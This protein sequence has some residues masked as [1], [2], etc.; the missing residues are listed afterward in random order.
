LE[1]VGRWLRSRAC[2]RT[3]EVDHAACI[4]EP[5]AVAVQL[6]AFLELPLNV[7]AMAAAVD[8]SLHRQRHGA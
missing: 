6:A 3:L 8:A 7:P 2:F 5:G 1:S 4:R